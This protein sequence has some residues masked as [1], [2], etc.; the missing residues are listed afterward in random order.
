MVVNNKCVSQQAVFTGPGV[1]GKA[2]VLDQYARQ[3]GFVGLVAL[4]PWM[5]G[6]G[7]RH[8]QPKPVDHTK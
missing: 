2:W 5:P 6:A 3:V 4:S 8:Q 7:Y 1:V